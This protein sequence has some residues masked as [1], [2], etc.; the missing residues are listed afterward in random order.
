LFF[1]DDDWKV[2]KKY[3]LLT[4]LSMELQEKITEDVKETVKKYINK[5]I[6]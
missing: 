3:T 4:N 1:E 2:F 5:D 6:S